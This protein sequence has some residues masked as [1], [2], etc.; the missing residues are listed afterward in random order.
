M[1]VWFGVCAD[2]EEKKRFFV[3]KTDKGEVKVLI[4]ENVLK[5]LSK[6]LVIFCLCLLRAVS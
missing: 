6:I 4:E 2:K 5:I 3:L 1:T